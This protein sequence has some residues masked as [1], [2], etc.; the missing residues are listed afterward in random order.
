[1][2]IAFRTDSSIQIGTG[3]VMRCLTLATELRSRGN[4]CVFICRSHEGDLNNLIA[5][6]GFEVHRLTGAEQLESGGPEGPSLAH[7]QWLG[8]SWWQDAEQSLSVLSDIRPDWLVIDHYALDACWEDLVGDSADKIMVIDDLADRQHSCHLLLDQNLGRQ[9]ED[10]N[11]LVPDTCAL[12]IG[13][14]YALLRPEFPKYRERSLERRRNPEL[15][16]ILISIGG[17]DRTN[18][19]GQVLDALTRVKL[20]EEAELDIVMGIAAPHLDIVRRKA[21]ELTCSATVSVNVSD[22]AERMCLADVAIGAAGGTAWERCCL[23]LPSILII[24]AENQ[25]AGTMAQKNAGV[26]MAIPNSVQVSELLPELVK[27]LTNPDVLREM[28]GAAASI[29]NGRGTDETVK[30]MER[31]QSE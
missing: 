10:Y 31:L 13:P 20:G 16:R 14:R 5:Q 15:K 28:S 6:K 4:R 3:H 9:A 27:K 23:G 12:L 19:T 11:G 18:V 26:A 25:V 2:L 30:R 1:M 29:T 22:M 24:L 17:V 8:T 21:E 7:T